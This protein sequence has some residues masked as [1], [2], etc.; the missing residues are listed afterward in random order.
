MVPE[1]GMVADALLCVEEVPVEPPQAMRSMIKAIH[2]PAKPTCLLQD[3]SLV[4]LP[5]SLFSCAHCYNGVTCR[6]FNRPLLDTSPVSMRRK[7]HES[8]MS[9]VIDGKPLHTSPVLLFCITDLDKLN[10]H[11]LYYPYPPGRGMDK[12]EHRDEGNHHGYRNYSSYR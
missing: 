2:T 7:R 9:S 3:I 11:R 4:S 8:V 10:S 1:A 6:Y 5:F 12:I